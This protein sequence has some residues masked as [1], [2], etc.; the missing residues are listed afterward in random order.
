MEHWVAKSCGPTPR[1]LRYCGEQHPGG[2]LQK[3]PTPHPPSSLS[4][5]WLVPLC[6]AT[7]LS[8][9]AENM[10]STL[11]ALRPAPG[12]PFQDLVLLLLP[13]VLLAHRATVLKNSLN[14]ASQQAGNIFN[15]GALGFNQPCGGFAPRAAFSLQPILS[16]HGKALPVPGKCLNKCAE[17]SRKRGAKGQMRQDTA[18]GNTSTRPAKKP[19]RGPPQAPSPGDGSP[20]LG[21]TRGKAAPQSVLF[22]PPS[23]GSL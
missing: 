17:Q 11:G 9:H 5:S 1:F 15:S 21:P 3:L 2:T 6:L 4:S 7:C 10:L 19:Q 18:A 8:S 13:H 12:G 23:L 16:R 22:P 14:S 20:L